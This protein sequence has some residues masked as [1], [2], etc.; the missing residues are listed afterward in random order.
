VALLAS[1]VQPFDVFCVPYNMPLWPTF[2]TNAYP[3]CVSTKECCAN[4]DGS[5]ASAQLSGLGWTGLVV[6]ELFARK[7]PFEILKSVPD[8]THAWLAPVNGDSPEQ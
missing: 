1:N 5:S 2:S 4:A 8:Y 6:W 3:W 7:V